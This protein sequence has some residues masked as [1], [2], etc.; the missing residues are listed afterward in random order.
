ME[1]IVDSRTLIKVKLSHLNWPE[2]AVAPHLVNLFAGTS[3][4]S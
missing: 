3:P 1:A 2:G 4:L